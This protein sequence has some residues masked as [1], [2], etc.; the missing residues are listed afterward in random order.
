[1]FGFVCEDDDQMR[2][3]GNGCSRNPGQKG[4]KMMMKKGRKNTS[5]IMRRRRRDMRGSIT[6][7]S[8]STQG[9]AAA[10]NQK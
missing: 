1:L 2:R 9:M 3:E 6:H 5:N 10:K 7:T 4:K 8:T